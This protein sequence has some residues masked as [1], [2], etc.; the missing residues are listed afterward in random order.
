MEGRVRRGQPLQP[1]VPDPE[2]RRHKRRRASKAKGG[3]PRPT[4]AG[5]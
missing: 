4:P 2:T 1:N 5:D 3:K